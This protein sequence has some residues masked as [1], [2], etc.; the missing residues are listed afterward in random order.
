MGVRGFSGAVAAVTAQMSRDTETEGPAAVGALGA[1]WGR[2]RPLKGWQCLAR[3][4]PLM[5]EAVRHQGSRGLDAG[6]QGLYEGSDYF[7]LMEAISDPFGSE[8]GKALHLSRREAKAALVHAEPSKTQHGSTGHGVSRARRR[9]VV[10]RR[11]TL[12]LLLV[13]V[14][15]LVGRLLLRLLGEV[16]LPKVIS[17][18]I[19]AES[20]ISRFPDRRHVVGRLISDGGQGDPLPRLRILHTGSLDI[21]SLYQLGH[22]PADYAA[23]V[24]NTSGDPLHG[25]PVRVGQGEQVD[26]QAESLQAQGG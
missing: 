15:G 3:L 10:G 12:P 23:A 18:G 17:L 9:L 20:L 5:L 13:E 24:R 7:H 25:G 2:R 16:I 26:E 1:L 19:A 6:R 21:A 8:R 22:G 4:W 11:R 14:A